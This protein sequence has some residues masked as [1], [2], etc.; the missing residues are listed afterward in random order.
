LHTVGFGDNTQENL[1]F[2]DRKDGQT[3]VAE[4]HALIDDPTRKRSSRL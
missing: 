2:I 3:D 1:V 4:F